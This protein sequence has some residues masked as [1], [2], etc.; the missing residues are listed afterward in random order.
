MPFATFI[1]FIALIAN[2]FTGCTSSDD[3]SSTQ[4]IVEVTVSVKDKNSNTVEKLNNGE[5]A[6]ITAT[7]TYSNDDTEILPAS[8]I[9]ITPKESNAF[10]AT[11]EEKRITLKA[12]E[13]TNDVTIT[14]KAKYKK[15]ESSKITLTIK[16]N[17]ST[18]D[19]SDKPNELEEPTEDGTTPT[20]QIAWATGGTNAFTITCSD[21]GAQIYYTMDGN[22]S[23][24]SSAKYTAPVTL[25]E[26]KTINA[27][28]VKSGLKDSEMATREMKIHTVTFDLNNGG[29]GTAPQDQKVRNGEKV[30]KPTGDPTHT[31]NTFKW[32]YLSSDNATNA[33]DFENKTITSNTTLKA[34]W[35]K[36][37][38][39]TASGVS[40]ITLASGGKYLF[41]GT[42]TATDFVTLMGK[43]PSSGT[44]I[45]MDFSQC[46][47]TGSEDI[48]SGT[49]TASIVKGAISKLILPNDL[50]KV[51]SYF[52]N[53][54]SLTSIT[55]G[56]A[57]NSRPSG[58]NY[59]W[60][61]GCSASVIYNGGN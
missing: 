38:F 31:D 42:I 33:F 24:A 1:T 57:E 54:S 60:I 52:A 13:I 12:K 21:S 25:T 36:D 44:P 45:E 17:S 23:T 39:N 43:I 51:P 9:E 32:W 49:S 2:T 18:Q 26:T 10:N 7:A 30:T 41:T 34:K 46:T 48:S 3:D 50:K 37:I 61:N 28:A 35:E 58:W 19:E 6:F 5:Q 22:T 47:I 55:V 16:G 59:G 29:S 53:T 15:I 4:K 8:C 40:D 56:W 11:K 14:I 27:I 20:P